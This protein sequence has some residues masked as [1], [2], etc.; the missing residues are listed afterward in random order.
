MIGSK[1]GLKEFEK[2]ADRAYPNYQ[3]KIYQDAEYNCPVGYYLYE[4]M[5]ADDMYKFLKYMYDHDIK[6][7]I[8][9]L[10]NPGG[11]I[12]EMWRN[13]GLMNDFKSRGMIIETRTSGLSASAAFVVFVNGTYGYRRVSPNALLMWHEIISAKMFDITTPA[14]KEDEARVLRKF[15]DIANVFLASRSKLSKDSLDEKIHKK[16]LW[17][18]GTEAVEFGFADN[19]IGLDN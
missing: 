4:R 8:I 5:A 14:D 10:H 6:H 7:V 16:E 9:E 12:F 3:M 18:T 11:S 13:V 17:L 2:D 1:F 19:F 15:Q